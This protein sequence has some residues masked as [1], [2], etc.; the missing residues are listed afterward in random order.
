MVHFL[1]FVIFC[2]L[3]VCICGFVRKDR[4]S[5][6]CL[7]KDTYSC[8]KNALLS[9][10]CIFGSFMSIYLWTRFLIYSFDIATADW[11]ILKVFWWHVILGFEFDWTYTVSLRENVTIERLSCCSC[12]CWD[13]S[14][15]C[16]W[17]KEQLKTGKDIFSLTKKKKFCAGDV[18]LRLIKCYA[19]AS[20]HRL[21]NGKITSRLTSASQRRGEVPDGKM[22]LQGG[23]EAW[24]VNVFLKA[25][26]FAWFTRIH[27]FN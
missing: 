3:A 18:K 11:T 24:T 1:G 9:S 17:V 26:P 5:I 15:F 12:S 19:A 2:S 22:K 16:P 21:S 13:S 10:I 14:C 20:I 7:L 8:Q 4:K 6:I 23:R 25:E 27:R